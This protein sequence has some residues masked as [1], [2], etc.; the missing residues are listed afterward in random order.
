[1]KTN[2][3]EILVLLNENPSKFLMVKVVEIERDG[4][5]YRIVGNRMKGGVEVFDG[6]TVVHSDWDK[7]RETWF[8][9]P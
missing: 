7:E 4:K 5:K 9:A 2:R 6:E 1:M 3:E 8:C